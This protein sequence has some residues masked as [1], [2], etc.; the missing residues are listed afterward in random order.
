M[1]EKR[2][3]IVK[4][5]DI[6]S[7]IYNNAKNNYESKGQRYGYYNTDGENEDSIENCAQ[8]GEK[9]IIL[10]I[11]YSQVNANEIQNIFIGTAQINDK[12]NIKYKMYR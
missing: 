3:F 10:L 1:K 12:W 7:E 4:N 6:K 11:S 5:N 8:I 2:I 9:G